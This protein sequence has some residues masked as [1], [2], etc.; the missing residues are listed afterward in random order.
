LL[1]VLAG[2]LE[3]NSG[4]V[5][6]D[7]ARLND[8]DRESLGRHVGYMPQNPTLF[9]AS[10]H[11]NISR[12]RRY[13]EPS[14]DYLDARVIEA[15][16]LAGA[17]DIILRFSQGY[18]TQLTTGEGGISAGQRQVVALARALFDSPTLLLLDEPNAHLDSGGEERLILTLQ[19]MRRRNATV[20]VSTHRTGILKAVDRIMV[21]RDGR[22]AMFGDRDEVFRNASQPQPT[23]EVTNAG[24]GAAAPEEELVNEGGSR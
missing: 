14:G 8:W 15:A 5:R 10:V 18:E 21:L 13:V 9:P 22:V 24:A 19:E 11:T 17:H 1:R 12:F 3:P 6:I 7:G 16:Q 4:E 2:A 20:V 23:P